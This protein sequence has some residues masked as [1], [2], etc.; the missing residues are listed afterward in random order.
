MR[1]ERGQI[2]GDVVVYEPFTLWGSIVGNVKVMEGGKLYMRGSVYGNMIVEHGG[3]VH[4]FGNVTGNLRVERKSKVIH[5]GIVGG[6]AHNIG[7]RL[8]IEPT[9][10]VYGKVKTSKEGETTQN[11]TK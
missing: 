7:G 1:E 6:D 5:S 4:I 8:H 2:I 10:R 11:E 9:G 3:R